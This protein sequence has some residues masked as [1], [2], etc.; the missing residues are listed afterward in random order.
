MILVY[1][2]GIQLM[3]SVMLYKAK[4]LGGGFGKKK[5]KKKWE[6]E[7]LAEGV[8]MTKIEN[9]LQKDT[10]HLD[11]ARSVSGGLKDEVGG[12]K[13]GGERKSDGGKSS[14]P[15]APVTV[16]VDEVVLPPPVDEVEVDFMPPSQPA[17]PEEEDEGPWEKHHDAASG[18][19]YWEN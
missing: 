10:R 2:V 1:P 16:Q 3:Y 15:A 9:P 14:V 18:H 11:L 13:K 4:E 8:E 6:N 17:P 19:D 7:V 12:K 5:G